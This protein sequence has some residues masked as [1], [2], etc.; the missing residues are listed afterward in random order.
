MINSGMEKLLMI[1]Q[2]AK[3]SRFIYLTADF[4]TFSECLILALE[5]REKKTQSFKDVLT[6]QVRKIYVFI[7]P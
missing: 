6:Q 7:G 2:T 5:L 1:N 4:I 3:D